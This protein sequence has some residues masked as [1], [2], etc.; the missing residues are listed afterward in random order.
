MK[1]EWRTLSADR[2]VWLI[3]ILFLG[4]IAYGL[5]NGVSWTRF[6]ETTLAGV[7]VSEEAR[8]EEMRTRLAE[9]DA[10]TTPAGFNDPGNPATAGGAGVRHAV[11][12]G[13][14]LAAFAV[15]QSDIYPY[16]VRVTTRE[17]ARALIKNGEMENPTNLLVGR[18]DIAFVIVFLFP[19]LIL[20]LSYNLLSGERENGTL[21]MVL[22][23]PVSLG[24]VVAGKVLLRLLLVGG[25]AVGL[26]LLGALAAGV[27]GG[28]VDGW[29]RFG[30]WT[31]VVLAYGLFWFAVAVGINALGR[32]SSWNAT[33]LL[34]IWL[35]MVVVAPALIHFAA[36]ALHPVPS[37]VEMIQ[38]MRVAAD[39]AESGRKHAAGTVLR[40]SPGNGHSCERRQPEQFA[41]RSLRGPGRDRAADGPRAGSLRFA[42]RLPAG[43]GGALPFPLAGDPRA[44]GAQRYLRHRLRALPAF[45]LRDGGISRRVRGL[46]HPSAGPRRTADARG[47]RWGPAIHL[48]G[49]A[50][51]VRGGSGSPL[52]LRAARSERRGRRG[53]A[54]RA[55]TLSPGLVAGR[56]T[57]MNLPGGR[58]P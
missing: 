15:G 7:A 25:L 39:D 20:A 8:L 27:L 10:G 53:R 40:G 30:L 42:A 18:F 6:Q 26:S 48:R 41:L 19:L 12:P 54:T 37:R 50:D 46:L 11:L 51:G 52:P 13:A 1:H 32:S 29:T 43:A 55:A 2:T 38:A 21:A 34:G 16:Y 28:A 33:A 23:H 44:G 57:A 56:Y 49:G 3:G 22:S 9:I 14:P 36:I 45:P 24:H 17:N 47:L 35:A 58:R 4:I 5:I 31:A